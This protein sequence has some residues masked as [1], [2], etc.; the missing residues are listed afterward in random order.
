MLVAVI[1]TNSCTSDPKPKQETQGTSSTQQQQ[2]Q[3][4]VF[5][6]RAVSQEHYA[7]T[8][9]EVQRFIE[10]LNQIIRNRNFN[11]WRDCLSPEYLANISRPEF[12]EELSESPALKTRRPPIVLRSV[13]DY[14]TH[15]VV[16]SRANLRVDDIEFLGEN[17][18]RAL[19]VRTL[20]SGEERRE[21]LYDLEKINNTW[22][23]IN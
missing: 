5:D 6:P 17:R 22:K 9:D 20:N 18:V 10:S 2:Q 13:Q 3:T 23:I 7:A 4:T 1:L 16:P 12:L 19:A 21:I 14:F 15:V 8:R 11:A